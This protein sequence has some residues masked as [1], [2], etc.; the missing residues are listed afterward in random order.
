[1]SV[2]AEFR[3]YGGTENS[4]NYVPNRSAVETN[5]WNSVPWNKKS[6]KLSEFGSGPSAEQKTLGISSPTVPQR[7]KMLEILFRGKKIEENS[8]NSVPEHVSDRNM[9]SILFAGAGFFVKLIFFMLFS[10]I[11]SPEL[12]LP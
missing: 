1:L 2:L 4:R 10:S 6:C 11:Q 5:A 3:L 9:P 12:T 8:W 7:R